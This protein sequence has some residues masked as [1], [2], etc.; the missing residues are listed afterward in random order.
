M[1]VHV[2]FNVLRVT[3][4]HALAKLEVLAAVRTGRPFLFVS[5][6]LFSYSIQLKR[7]KK[8]LFSLVSIQ[9]A[10]YIFVSLDRRL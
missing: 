1:S 3:V 9:D 4:I 5:P 8:I 6:Q 7:Q 10:R 2:Q